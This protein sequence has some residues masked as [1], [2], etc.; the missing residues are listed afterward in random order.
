MTKEKLMRVETICSHRMCDCGGEFKYNNDNVM[1]DI[2]DSLLSSTTSKYVH[3]CN[4]CGAEES[5]DV[6]YPKTIE[7]EIPV[8]LRKTK[9]GVI[10][11]VTE[12]GD[13]M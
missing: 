4:K 2:L 12:Y 1:M 3:K 5:F 11:S 7:L 10:Y 6:M 9:D 13:N 8:E